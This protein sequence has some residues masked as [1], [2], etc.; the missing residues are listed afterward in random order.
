MKKIER[1]YVIGDA[2]RSCR[3]SE[4]GGSFGRPRYA[5]P[6]AACLIG[7]CSAPC[8]LG[9]E[10]NVGRYPRVVPGGRLPLNWPVRASCPSSSA[11]SASARAASASRRSTG[12]PCCIHR[13]CF[14][15]LPE[16]LMIAS[17]LPFMGEVQGS[18]VRAGRGPAAAGSPGFDCSVAHPPPLHSPR[19]FAAEPGLSNISVTGPSF[20]SETS[21]IAPKRPVATGSPCSRSI[22]LNRS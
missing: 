1:I 9:N 8:K 13:T 2:D 19:A 11:H 20:T 5:I 12:A 21:I 18:P 22:A 7:G 10:T 16:R 17:R 14:A 6:P 3:G 4:R 15:S